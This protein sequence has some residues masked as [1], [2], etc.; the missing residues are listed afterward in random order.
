[1]IIGNKRTQNGA[2]LQ[3]F[4]GQKRTIKKSKIRLRSHEKATSHTSKNYLINRSIQAAKRGNKK[5]GPGVGARGM[6]E[7]GK[8]GHPAAQF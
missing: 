3:H 7:R 2:T 5:D 8:L 4:T 1:V 6:E